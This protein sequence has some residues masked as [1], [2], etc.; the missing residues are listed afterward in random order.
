MIEYAWRGG[1]KN[2]GERGKRLRETRFQSGTVCSILEHL[3]R[4]AGLSKYP[5]NVR[6]RPR[7]QSDARV[8]NETRENI[9]LTLFI[10]YGIPSV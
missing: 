5:A 3:I 1:A 6:N 8:C 9:A 4:M 7:G 10:F 2:R